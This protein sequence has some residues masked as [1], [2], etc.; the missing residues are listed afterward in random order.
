MMGHTAGRL[1]TIR[2]RPTKKIVIMAVRAYR[3]TPKLRLN[4][5]TRR[6]RADTVPAR[7]AMLLPLPVPVPVPSVPP[8][9]WG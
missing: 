4:G 8:P 3:C 1:W 9:A 7:G 2:P 5:Q 6:R